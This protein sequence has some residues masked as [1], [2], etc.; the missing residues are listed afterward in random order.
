VRALGDIEFLGQA[1]CTIQDCI[2]MWVLSEGSDNVTD[3][4]RWFDQKSRGLP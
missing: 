4:P 1:G 3:G 2:P